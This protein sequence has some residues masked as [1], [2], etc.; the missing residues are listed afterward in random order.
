M[1]TKKVRRWQVI[2]GPRQIFSGHDAEGKPHTYHGGDVFEAT[3]EEVA[4]G[5]RQNLLAYDVAT[6]YTEPR[7]V[8][9]A[10]V[11]D[12]AEAQ[13]LRARRRTPALNRA[14]Q[15]PPVAEVM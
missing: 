14:V 13:R 12:Q 10:H 1:E 15:T 11:E 6:P 8:E 4:R 5:Q 3:E 2:G 7:D 9:T